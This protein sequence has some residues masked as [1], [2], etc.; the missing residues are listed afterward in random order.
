MAQAASGV[1]DTRQT[2]FELCTAAIGKSAKKLAT[3][4]RADLECLSIAPQVFHLMAVFEIEC[5]ATLRALL[6]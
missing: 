3:L 1:A 4:S 5:A 6:L 2:S